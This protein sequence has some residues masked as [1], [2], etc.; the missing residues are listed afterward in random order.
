MAAAAA[1]GDDGVT[2]RGGGWRRWRAWMPAAAGRRK[3]DERAEDGVALQRAVMDTADQE[4]RKLRVVV[5]V[6]GNKGYLTMDEAR[7]V[8]GRSCYVIRRG[9]RRSLRLRGWSCT[10]RM[11]SCDTSETESQCG[12]WILPANCCIT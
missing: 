11:T 12:L 5:T 8:C 10:I 7:A 3:T 1:G 6:L 9:T 4:E 2:W